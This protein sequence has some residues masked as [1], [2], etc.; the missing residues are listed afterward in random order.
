MDKPSAA[1]GNSPSLDIY[2]VAGSSSNS[3]SGSVR[4]RCCS[5]AVLWGY[6][7]YALF[8][9]VLGPREAGGRFFRFYGRV[10]PYYLMWLPIE[11][12]FVKL[13]FLDVLFT[14]SL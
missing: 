8:L 11:F 2:D 3:I 5:D 10:L 6:A 7:A 12:V 1:P 14:T 13:S 4:S 9:Y